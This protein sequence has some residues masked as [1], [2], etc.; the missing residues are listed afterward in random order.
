MCRGDPF[1]KLHSAVD[2][3]VRELV[4]EVLKYYVESVAELKREILELAVE[5]KLALLENNTNTA[6]E[7]LNKLIALLS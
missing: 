5:A 7:K 6:V 1:E 4:L 3:A 2:D